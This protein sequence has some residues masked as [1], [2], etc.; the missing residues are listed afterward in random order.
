MSMRSCRTWFKAIGLVL[1]I[2]VASHR[3]HGSATTAASAN[4]RS[5]TG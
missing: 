4:I 5:P 3:R 2:V 1:I